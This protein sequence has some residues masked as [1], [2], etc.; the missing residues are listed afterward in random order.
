MTI[1]EL[2]LWCK[3]QG[4]NVTSVRVGDCEVQIM[5]TMRGGSVST[6]DRGPTSLYE[7]YAPELMDEAFRAA[8]GNLPADS[9]DE[10]VPVVTG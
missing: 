4:L 7:A 2:I 9:K 5:P 8:H 6:V 10:L 1:T 3:E